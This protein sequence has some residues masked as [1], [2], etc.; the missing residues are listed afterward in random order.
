MKIYLVRHGQTMFNAKHR[1]QGWCDSPLTE[2]GV[3]QAQNVGKHLMDVPFVKAYCSTSERV[4]DTATY[5]LNGR[6]IELIERKDLKEF[7]FGIFEAD[8][9]KEVFSKRNHFDGFVDVGGENVQMVSE[10]M[11]TAIVDIA[12]SNPE[13]NVLVVSHGGA[14]MNLFHAIDHPFVEKMRKQGKFIENCSVSIFNYENEQLSIEV[15][16]DCSYRED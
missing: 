5:I 1:V 8:L 7:N 9:E 12:K 11:Y 6:D 2:L 16:G 3:K 4:V 14:I 10:R 15:F 13:G